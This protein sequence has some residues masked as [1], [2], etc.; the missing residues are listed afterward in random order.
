MAKE[1]PKIG[2][3][4]EFTEPMQ[5]IRYEVPVSVMDKLKEK[6]DKT[7]VPVSELVRAA[8]LSAAEET[9]PRV[10]LRKIS[11]AAPCGPFADVAAGLES[12]QIPGEL[13]ELLGVLDDDLI[14]PC[15]GHSMVGADIDDGSV[16]VMRPLNGLQPHS[17]EVILAQ[18]TLD[19]GDCLWT[20]KYWHDDGRW[21]TLE[22]GEHEELGFPE[23]TVELKPVAR[24]VGTFKK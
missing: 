15:Q 12:F 9:M 6:K 7:R 19:N 20:V 11:T 10:T 5:A 1:K 16:L 4:K 21:V 17:G 14:V 8:L 23:N 22:D 2:R 13:A 3:P 24:K 18:V